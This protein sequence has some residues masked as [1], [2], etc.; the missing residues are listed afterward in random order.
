MF[1]PV[2]FPRRASGVRSDNL[3]LAIAE[4]GALSERSCGAVD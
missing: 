1:C 4:I 3:A 2:E